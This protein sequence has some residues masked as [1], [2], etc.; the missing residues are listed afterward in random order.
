MFQCEGKGHAVAPGHIR[1]T[2]LRA[3]LAQRGPQGHI[4]SIFTQPRTIRG[5]GDNCFPNLLQTVSTE[6]THRY[7]SNAENVQK[8]YISSFP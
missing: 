4:E 2:E 7:I 1:V 3:V 6:R 5:L 8:Y